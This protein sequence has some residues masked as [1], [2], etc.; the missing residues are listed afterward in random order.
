[1]STVQAPPARPSPAERITQFIERNG[2]DHKRWFIGVTCNPREQLICEHCINSTRDPFLIIGCD[3]ADE[4][5]RVEYSLRKKLGGWGKRFDGL[6]PAAIF[7]YTF[8]L[9]SATVPNLT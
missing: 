9:S 6:D 1:M 5:R 7:V 8:R 3:T 2:G 4:A